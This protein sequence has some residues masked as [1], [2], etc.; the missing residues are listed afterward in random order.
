M[1]NLDGLSDATLRAEE[2]RLGGYAAED[3]SLVAL[4]DRDPADDWQ[5]AIVF[6]DDENS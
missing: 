5:Y 2:G 3:A 1:R 6:N 4:G